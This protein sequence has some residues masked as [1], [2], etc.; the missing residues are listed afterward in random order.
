MT[1]TN[2]LLTPGRIRLH[3]YQLI[4]LVVILGLITGV[5]VFWQKSLSGSSQ[6]LAS[7]YHLSSNS[8]YLRA[9]LELRYI[10]SH[11][12]LESLEKSIDS[13]LQ[14]S[15]QEIQHEYSDTVSFY[16]VRDELHAALALQDEFADGRFDPLTDKLRQQLFILIEGDNDDLPHV[17]ATPGQMYLSVREML[18]TLKQLVQ[19]HTVVRGDLL[20]ELEARKSRQNTVFIILLFLL[21]V[22]GFFI[23]RRSLLAIDSL[24]IDHQRVE[25]ALYDS[26]KHYRNLV[27]T[28]AAVAFEID[29]SS[30]SFRYISPQIKELTGYPA[31]NW[32]DFDFWSQCIHPDDRET[33]IAYCQSET[34]KGRDHTFEYR[35]LRHDGHVIWVRDVVSLVKEQ[36]QAVSLRG[37]IVDIT[38]RKQVELEMK[39]NEQWL[40][41]LLNTLPNGVQECDAKGRIIFSNVAHHRI[42]GL[43][44]GELIGKNVWDFQPG[45]NSKQD[46]RDYLAFLVAEKPAPEPYVITNATRDGDEVILE[47]TWDYQYGTKGEVTGF[48]SI[49]SDITRRKLTEDRLKKSEKS[50]NQALQVAHLGNWELDLISKELIWSDE[51]Y[52]IFEIDPENDKAGFDIF[53]EIIH[54]EDR[55]MVTD[56]FENSVQNGTLY[57]VEHRLLMKDGRIKYLTERAETIYD[58]NNHPLRSIGV[59]QDITKFKHTELALRRSQKMDAVGQMAGGIAHD[60]NNILSIVLGNIEMLEREITVDVKAQKRIDGIK[61]STQRAVDLTRQLLGFSRGK[62][63]SKKVININQRLEKMQSLIIR[64]LTPQVE[65]SEQLAED[66]WLVEIDPGDFEDA[67]LNLLLNARDAMSGNGLLT[68]E[69]RN[70]ELD[71]AYCDI[72]PD[73]VPGKYVQLTVSDTGIGLSSEVQEHI[74]EPFFTTKHQGEGTGLGLS[75]VYGF[76][77]R[78]GGC[79]KVYSESGI[80][81]T[82]RIFLPVVT[83]EAQVNEKISGNTAIQPRGTETLLLVDDEMALLELAEESLQELGYRV[84]TANNGKQ[85]L[86]KLAEERT[87]DLLF[88]DVVMPG[89]I[90]GFEL[91]EQA[92]VLLPG[93]KVLITSGYTEKTIMR[94]GQARFSEN[95]L[96][97]PYNQADLAQRVR[98]ALDEKPKESD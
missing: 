30:M 13:N 29:L 89:G 33:T 47:I 62:A 74:F 46:T 92:V 3:I 79:I 10:Q 63:T 14:K 78:S 60:F 15:S 23:I 38:D 58:K 71:E 64:S 72:T 40:I 80:G 81:T 85:A 84:L 26:E 70:C 1:T 55:A 22:F 9:M 69:T 83:K 76:V 35:M 65:V 59:V 41:Q 7:D 25:K 94:N 75:M 44:P 96:S 48:I 93:L 8:H 53:V 82:F 34:A 51:V 6:A 37:F 50:L 95:M 87:V 16:L 12:I 97:K 56:A 57:Q 45:K 68:I 39:E 77:K 20:A 32:V 19:L 2:N 11:S 67:L 17:D 52:K 24:I 36:G 61:H 66:L 54:P 27:E 73:I 86:Q 91:A 28:T 4:S 98:E 88:S 42:L 43:K 18:K 21:F 90:N 31:E 5:Y 49:I